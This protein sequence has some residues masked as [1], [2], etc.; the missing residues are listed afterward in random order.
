MGYLFYSDLAIA[1]ANVNDPSFLEENLLYTEVHE[2]EKERDGP[3]MEQ[4]DE[5]PLYKPATADDAGLNPIFD[6]YVLL[7]I[8][9]LK[10]ISG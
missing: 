10:N 5:N 3:C 7:N 8:N 2:P 6:G 9:C 4:T 1:N